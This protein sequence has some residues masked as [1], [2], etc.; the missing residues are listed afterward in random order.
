MNPTFSSRLFAWTLRLLPD[1]FR[2]AYADDM[3][4]TFAQRSREARLGGHAAHALFITRELAAVSRVALVERFRMMPGRHRHHSDAWVEIARREGR[5]AMRRL[6]R[7]PA[8]SAMAV[9]TLALAIGANSAVFT[10]LNRIV[11]ADFPYP[12]ADRVIA[13][14][15]IAPGTPGGLGMSIGVYREYAKLPSIEAIALFD[16]AEGTLGIAA[17]STLAERVSY[18]FTTP[19]LGGI[20]GVTM[21]S[22][23]WLTNADG[24]AGAPN[25]VVLT[26]ALWRSHFGGSPSVI[27]TTLQLDG[28]AHEIVGVVSPAVV[29]PDA[30]TQLVIPLP[31]PQVWNRAAGFNYRGIARLAPGASIDD[32]RRE[33]NALLKDLPARYPDDAEAQTGVIGTGQ[34]RSTAVTFKQSIVGKTTTTLWVLLSAVVVLLAVACANLAN[35]FLVRAESRHKEVAMRRALGASPRVIAGYFLGESLIIAIL[36]GVF[37]LAIAYVSVR[38]LV[39]GA[40]VPLPRLREVRFDALSIAFTVGASLL[41]GLAFGLL[42]LAR[43]SVTRSSPLNDVERSGSTSAAHMRA[44]HVLMGAQVALAVV[45]LA[46]AGLMVRSFV[47]LVRVDPGFQ[48]DS[49]LV[50]RVG[51]PRS[52]YRTRVDAARFHTEV[53]ARLAD[54]PGVRRVGLTT[55]LPLDG[56][57]IGNPIEVLGAPGR[58]ADASPVVRLRRI[59]E[60]Y[61]PTMGIRV[62]DGRAP[63]YGGIVSG[64]IVINEALARAYFGGTNPIGRQVRQVGEAGQTWLTIVGVVSNTVTESLQETSPSPQLFVA[65]GD[66][67]RG[68]TPAPHDATY[69]LHVSGDPN[70][71]VPTVRRALQGLNPNVPVWRPEALADVVERSRA[72][73]SFTLV[74]LVTAAAVALVLGV[75]GVYAVIA[76]SVAQRS[77]EIGVRLALGAMPRQV[78]MLIVRESGAV[79]LAGVVLG[80]GAALVGSRLLRALLFGVAANDAATYLLTGSLLFTIATAAAWLPARRAAR[81]TP[82]E[83]L[84]HT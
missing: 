52:E 78:T 34:L 46:A 77:R 13:L 2:G 14:D 80:T 1:D 37:G 28:A 15:H 10:L 33:Q 62:V 22:G 70:S 81:L 63:D 58:S 21:T 9:L 8:F 72:N 56:Q 27:G 79:I 40:P 31:L 7:T 69:V 11:L 73:L 44:R 20:L 64:E 65:L 4:E 50:F 59:S 17:G 47:N 6:M 57:G 60:E 48:T 36:G 71:L 68:N 53:L 84:R 26:D 19:A 55:T 5:H 24:V 30:A 61:L 18:V 51:L 41:S 32:A 42:C 45:L 39:L 82:S 74:L 49:R 83:A 54:L 75:V 29:F 3:M 38:A 67:V 16:I 23:R 76:Y 25:V 12:N 35:L 66:T 43:H